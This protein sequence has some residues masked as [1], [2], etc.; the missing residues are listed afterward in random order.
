MKKIKLMF[1]E[2]RAIWKLEDIAAYMPIEKD[3][4]LNL[5]LEEMNKKAEG[6]HK[7]LLDH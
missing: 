1:E 6:I 7:L 4:T 5:R 2:Y 3:D